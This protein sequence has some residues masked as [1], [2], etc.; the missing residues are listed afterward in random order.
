MIEIKN[1]R[2][3]AETHEW[4]LFED[5]I[6]YIGITD[7]AQSEL[8][9]IVYVESEE[10]G[11][12]FEQG[13]IFGS[14]ESVKM[15]SDLYMPIDGEI[16]EFNEILADEPELINED[17]YENWIIKVKVTNPD[18]QNDLLGVKEY[19]AVIDEE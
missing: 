13:E 6:A 18:Q 10:E 12:L 2:Y 8:G 4:I 14:V 11:E 9:D 19:Q 1:D 7:F 17:A 15:A 5:D 3:Y 16:L